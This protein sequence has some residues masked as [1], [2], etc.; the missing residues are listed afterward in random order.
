LKAGKGGGAVAAPI[1]GA[2]MNFYFDRKKKALED[3][4]L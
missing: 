3:G 1:A 2:F 4:K